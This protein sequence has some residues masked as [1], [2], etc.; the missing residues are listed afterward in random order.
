MRIEMMEFLSDKI[1][2]INLLKKLILTLNKMS[3]NNLKRF[4]DELKRSDYNE[5]ICKMMIDLNEGKEIT[6]EQKNIMEE[7]KNCDYNK[8]VLDTAIDRDVLRKKSLEKQIK[9]MKKIYLEELEKQKTA[10]H[11][12]NMR[13]ISDVTEFK[14]YLNEL[15]QELGK[16]TDVKSDTVVLKFSPDKKKER[17]EN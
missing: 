10:I 13:K 5:Y 11:S 6:K 7:L 12:E 17:K 15:K 1:T 16:D 8:N 4:L 14:M 2:D 9:L 3:S